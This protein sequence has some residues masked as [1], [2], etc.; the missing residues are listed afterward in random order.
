MVAA[1]RGSLRR[2]GSEQAALGQLH[3]SASRCAALTP[4]DV[5]SEHSHVSASVKLLMQNVR[6]CLGEEWGE[7]VGDFAARSR[8]FMRCDMAV[9][10]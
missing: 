5:T 6:L 9:L 1:C 10:R 3:W 4:D 7:G 8:A 2:L